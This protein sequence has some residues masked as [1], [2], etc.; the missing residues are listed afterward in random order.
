MNHKSQ[1]RD[2][3]CTCGHVRYQI[4]SKPLIVHC[5]HCCGCQKNSGSSFA[6]NAL[7]EAD[8][9]ELIS[10]EIEEILVPT[11]SG[12]GQTITRCSKCKVAVWSNYNM[13]GLR[14][15]IRFIRVGTLDDSDQFP[16]DVHIYTR[17]KQPWV[18]LPKEDQK[19][20]V[21]YEFREAWSPESMERLAKIEKSVGIKIS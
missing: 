12:T 14:E 20:D 1:T 3:G 8:R 18:I 9:V 19:V 7:F 4:T 15:R 13:G 5:C 11:P 10:G 6:L 17:S 21:F 2:G 16:P